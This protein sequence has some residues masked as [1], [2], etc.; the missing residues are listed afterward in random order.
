MNDRLD[1]PSLSGFGID[2][3]AY[4]N[5]AGQMADDAVRSGAPANNPRVGSVEE[6]TDLFHEAWG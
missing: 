3:A 5:A 2:H 1:V 6:I 4:S